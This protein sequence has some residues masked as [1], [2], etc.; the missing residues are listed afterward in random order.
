MRSAAPILAV[1][2]IFL[3]RQP[4]Y[5][6]SSQ[7]TTQPDSTMPQTIRLWPGDAPGAT[8]QKDFDI[9]TLTI[10]R[11]DRANGTA[12][13]VCPGGGYDHLADHEGAPV[14]RWLNTL[15]IT[16]GV[17][18]YRLGSHGYRH[19]VELEDMQRAMRFFR[20]DACHLNLDPTH[21]GA[22]G[23]SAGGHLVSTVATHFDNGDLQSPDPIER[24]SCRPDVAL[25]IYPV[26]TMGKFAHAP[27]RKELLGVNPDPKLIDLLSNERQVTPRTPPC[28]IV[29]T[30]DDRT[31]PVENS[32]Q[33]AQVCRENHVP[34]ELHI[35]EHGPHGFG[36][37]TKDPALG[38]WP[39]DAALFLERHGFV[40]NR[41]TT[42][43][44]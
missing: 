23:F 16:A 40:T 3:I 35:F 36:M 34:F 24:A 22:I 4:M 17:L 19:P 33:F 37:G 2:A 29:H 27:S 18:K 38:T 14:A 12:M 32:I 43:K 13:I 44:P 21:I 30:S 39:A 25:L 28:F 7:P 42:T 1:I 11:P 8:G 31:V 41:T 10:Y 5:A 20:S 15:G 9:P 6:Q 26:I